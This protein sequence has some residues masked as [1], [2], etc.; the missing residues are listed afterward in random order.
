[1]VAIL[2]SKLLRPIAVAYDDINHRV[3][4]TDVEQRTISS[5]SLFTNNSHTTTVFLAHDGTLRYVL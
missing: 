2:P 4:W 5:Y 1:M 3:Y